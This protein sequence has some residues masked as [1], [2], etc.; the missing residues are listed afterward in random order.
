MTA[1][2]A[3]ERRWW[4]FSGRRVLLRSDWAE[5]DWSAA[6]LP[7]PRPEAPLP[8]DGPH[9]SLEIAVPAGSGIV[10]RVSPEA[11]GDV[12]HEPAQAWLGPDPPTPP[13]D[14]L[15]VDLRAAASAFTP[16]AFRRAGRAWQLLEWRRTHR[17]C[18]VC[19]SPTAP[20]PYDALTCSACD[21]LHFPR[22][23]PAVIV[24]VHD[25]DRALL[26]RSSHLPDGMYST[27]AGFVEPGESLEQTVHR[28]ILEEADVEVT[29]VRYFG[30]Q[31][32]PFPHSLMVGFFA[33]WSRGTPR[34]AD[35]ELEDVA[36][37]H[38][39]DLP[40]IP[41]RVSIARSLI[42]AWRERPAD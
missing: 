21:H 31:P 18:G 16:D 30:S 24:L 25:G 35:G 29:D 8:T 13:A 11:P 32:W 20:G 27:L 40:R 41:G 17:F 39:D 42:D 2:K 9:Q 1:S 19:G 4:V 14:Y 33:R 38:R 6:S 10:A 28:E 15:W 36:W 7:D 22:L 3:V 26:G 37:F 5:A 34:P 12:D 23:S